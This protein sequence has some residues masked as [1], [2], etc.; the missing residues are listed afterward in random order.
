MRRRWRLVGA[1]VSVVT[2][3]VAIMVG[4]LELHGLVRPHLPEW[5]LEPMRPAG[6]FSL[7]GNGLLFALAGA[8][9][10]AAVLFPWMLK[11][12][13]VEQSDLCPPRKRDR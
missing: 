1:C 10:L 5:T 12:W 3:A 8:I 9:C 7:A 13:R 2:L 11:V 4:A 6:G